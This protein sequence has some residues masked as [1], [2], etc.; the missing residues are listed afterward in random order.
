[1]DGIIIINKEKNCTSHDVVK[2]V[3]NIFHEKVGHTGTLDPNATGVLP[4]LVGQ[5]T[6]M[7]QY[8]IEHDKEYEVVLKL[9]AKTTTADSEG[10]ILE[11]QTVTANMMQEENVQK[12]LNSFLGEQEQLPPIYSAIKIKGKKLYEYARESKKVDIPARK[13]H[14][15]DIELN[16]INAQEK[17]IYFKVH[18]SKGTYIRSLCEDIASKLGTIGYMKELNRTKVGQFTINEAVNIRDL[19]QNSNNL[20][21]IEEYFITIEQLCIN[22]YGKEK[23]QILNEKKLSLFLNGVNL[24]YELPE[25]LYRI[26]NTKKQ[27][28]GIGLAKNNRLK[29]E[30]IVEN[31]KEM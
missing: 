22:L 14:I 20:T 25:G 17:E 29:R 1:M 10:E 23:Y 24:T 27:F 21:F 5:G 11:T 31:K 28:I 7:S 8:L 6:K 16:N 13:I 18:C 19:E 2:K 3:K 15:Y 26:Y 9:G 12:I 4:L 30:I